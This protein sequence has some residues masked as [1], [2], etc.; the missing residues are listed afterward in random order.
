MQ[1]V[2][3]LYVAQSLEQTARG[4]V[5]TKRPALL[6]SAKRVLKNSDSLLAE[7]VMRP[8]ADQIGADSKSY[9]SRCL[10]SN[11]FLTP[12]IRKARAGQLSF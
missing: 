1:K 2:R 7:L 10:K 9:R 4:R 5:E 8:Q 6:G 11:I 3:T 12:A